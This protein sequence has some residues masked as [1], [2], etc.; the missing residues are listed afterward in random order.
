MMKVIND[1]GK[2]KSN[3][4][5]FLEREERE[6]EKEKEREIGK[7]K[8]EVR[9]LCSCFDSWKQKLSLSGSKNVHFMDQLIHSSSP[10][11]SLS[12]SFF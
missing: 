4:S 6:R 2:K 9:V 7:K 8:N 3:N 5:L 12:F 11:F 10:S 1:E